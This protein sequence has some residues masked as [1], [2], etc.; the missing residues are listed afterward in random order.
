MTAEQRAR[1]FDRFWRGRVGH[2]AARGWASR[3]CASSSRRTRARSSSR[4]RPAAASTRSSACA[5]RDVRSARNTRYCPGAA[6]DDRD[7]STDGVCQPGP[8]RAWPMTPRA[9][10]PERLELALDALPGVGRTVAARKLATLGLRTVRDALEH[11]PHRYESAVEEVAIARSARGRGGRDRR[12]GAERGE[13]PAARAAGARDRPRL[14]RLRAGHRGLVQPAVGR[15]PAA[16]GHARPAARQARPL[17]LRRPLVRPRRG[18][19]PPPTSRRCTRPRRRS[20]RRRCAASSPP[21]CRTSDDVF[22]PLPAELREHEALPLKRDALAV[23]H[24]PE[25]RGRGRDRPPAARVR[26]A[27][28]A[29]DRDRPARR[30]A[31]AD[32]RAGARRA[33]RARPP[34]PRGA[35]VRAH[36]LPGAG[37]PRDRRR[38]RA[39]GADAAAAPGRRRLRQDGR[40]A[41]RAPARG[42]G[43][44]PG[45]ADGADGDARRAALPHDRRPLPRA[46]R[47]VRA[48]DERARRPRPRR[49]PRPHRLGRGADRRRH[50]RADPARGR[51]PRPRRRRRRR[52][53]PLRRRAAQRARAGTLAARPAHDRDA[54]PAD[55]RAH[56]LRRPRRLGDREAARVAQADRHELDRGAPR[57]RGVHASRRGSCARAARRTSS[58]RSSRPPRRRSPAPPRRRPSGCAAPSSPTSRSAACTAA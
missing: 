15:R 14:R 3:S 16:A 7:P 58:A 28:P 46:R 36:A 20:R 13:A 25:S 55:A 44:P 30:R 22:D 19:A 50:A 42:R 38:P 23:V 54:D 39:H 8:A 48:A 40:R 57:L 24:H 6:H 17:R 45:R 4:R 53:A 31:R 51:V 56:R 37:D 18:A 29:P 43:R 35:P 49:R 34:L 10:R 12:R 27:A 32:A 2:T 9:P 52:A 1:A 5:G 41:L 26:G 11:R 21:R 47:H 33:G